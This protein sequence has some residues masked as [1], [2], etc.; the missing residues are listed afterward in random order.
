MQYK[1][2]VF[3]YLVF[4]LE[5]RKIKHRKVQKSGFPSVE[6]KAIAIKFGSYGLKALESCRLTSAQIET[7]RKAMVYKLN[8]KRT[9]I[10]IRVFPNLPVSGKSSEVR[11]GGGKGMLKFWAVHVPAGH[12]L[13]EIAGVSL[14]Q[15]QSIFK[16]VSDKLPIKSKFISFNI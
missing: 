12:V 16:R 8:K 10:W 3:L 2:L 6:N 5:P 9:R 1:S 14:I 13:F 4:M 15:A 7:A 11:M